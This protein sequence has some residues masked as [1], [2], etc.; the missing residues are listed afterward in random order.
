MRTLPIRTSDVTGGGD[1]RS[2][3]AGVALDSTVRADSAGGGDKGSRFGEFSCG[4]KSDSELRRFFRGGPVGMKVGCSP[5]VESP[6][7]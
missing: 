5:I 7:L 4:S 6:R 3:L 1:M 2:D